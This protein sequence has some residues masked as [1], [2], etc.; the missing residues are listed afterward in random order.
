LTHHADQKVI[1][2]K[3]NFVCPLGF[4][5]WAAG[6]VRKISIVP[7]SEYLVQQQ[8]YTL[9]SYQ[10]DFLPLEKGKYHLFS[11]YDFQV[12][13]EELVLNLKVD[14]PADK[15]LLKYIR[16]KIIDKNESQRKYPTQTE[17]QEQLNMLRLEN[18]VFPPNNGKGYSL[19]IEGVMPY[20]SAEG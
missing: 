3:P 5:L 9:K 16:L 1:W 17:Y 4:T 20:N 18:M 10:S 8:Q 14:I 7:R 6:Q 15:H 13:D 19:L 2:L 12:G 11:R